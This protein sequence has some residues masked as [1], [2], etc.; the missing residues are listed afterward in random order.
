MKESPILTG[1]PQPDLG[2]VHHRVVEALRSHAGARAT[3]AAAALGLA[4]DAVAAL[5]DPQ[6]PL[7]PEAITLLA[8]LD[9]AAATPLAIELLAA[10]HPGPDERR[11]IVEELT[12]RSA[13]LPDAAR[14]G[15]FFAWTPDPEL[16]PWRWPSRPFTEVHPDGEAIVAAMAPPGTIDGVGVLAHRLIHAADELDG[17]TSDHETLRRLTAARTTPALRAL[18]HAATAVLDQQKAHLPPPLVAA[19]A[20]RRWMP[21]EWATE[22]IGAGRD[23]ATHLAVLEQAI[24]PLLSPGKPER[25]HDV[26]RAA[27][28]ALG[29]ARH[30]PA[31]PLLAHLVRT[32][33]P[34]LSAPAAEAL[35]R[36][37]TDAARAALGELLPDLLLRRSDWFRRE[38]TA[39]LHGFVPD[40]ARA[41]ETLGEPFLGEA[42]LATPDGRRRVWSILALRGAKDP[43]FDA[44]PRWPELAARLLAGPSFDAARAFLA[45]FEPKVVRAALAAVGYAPPPPPLPAKHPVPKKPRWLE[46]YDKGE[47][48][49]V[50]AEIVALEDS[51]Q[52]PA[53]AE[54]AMAVA[55]AM[56]GR[57]RQNLEGIVE[58]LKKRKYKFS[59]KSATKALVPPHAKVGAHIQ[60]LE[61]LAG[62]PLPLSLRAFWEVVGSVDL[63]EL[64]AA[65]NTAEGL[66][67]L[68]PLM[69]APP[70]LPLDLLKTRVDYEK[71]LPVELRRPV[72]ELPIGLDPATKADAE[73]HN[74]RPYE[75]EIVGTRAD[76]VLRQGARATTFVGYLRGAIAAGGFPGKAELDPELDPRKTLALLAA[77]RTTF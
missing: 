67:L 23:P 66:G 51:A 40:A 47:H 35:S 19:V 16:P 28:A 76:G 59:V 14:A 56:M 63:T 69:V 6:G 34:A 8:K 53:V 44:D 57:V 39:A 37:G 18:R 3:E 68:D 32:D 49:A 64:D 7:A 42:A 60:A 2:A 33:D 38:Q 9:P 41:T 36:Y 24:G 71:R 70:K 48:E 75:I 10:L 11:A 15:G 26:A 74:A 1:A 21:D 20:R 27:I 52:D 46:R 72:V 61:K 43:W 55:R 77:G 5:T 22:A 58:T 31:V 45:T 29:A 13:K 54:E 62:G 50:W 12:K 30:D 25:V 4:A 73:E 17:G 65:A